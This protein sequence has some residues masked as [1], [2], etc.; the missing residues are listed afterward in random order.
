MLLI[1]PIAAKPSNNPLKRC[2]RVKRARQKYDK[3]EEGVEAIVSLNKE[4]EVAIP[5]PRS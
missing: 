5:Y 2:V 4:L 1:I 3:E